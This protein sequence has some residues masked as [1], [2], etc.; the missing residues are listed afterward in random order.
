MQDKDLTQQIIAAMKSDAVTSNW[1]QKMNATIDKKVDDRLMP[2]QKEI[3]N[4]KEDN[5]Q[6]DSTIAKIEAKIDN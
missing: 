1:I 6:R 2:I 3:A 5:K 4:M